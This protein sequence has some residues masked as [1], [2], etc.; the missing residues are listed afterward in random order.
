MKLE[1][2]CLSRTSIGFFKE[3]AVLKL[4]TPLEYDVVSLEGVLNHE[5][6]THI[7]RRLNH[8]DNCIRRPSEKGKLIE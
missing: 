7:L 6:G 1:G 5:V 4:R 2:N 8:K 3:K